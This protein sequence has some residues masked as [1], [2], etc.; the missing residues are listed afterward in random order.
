M[1][2]VGVWRDHPKEHKVKADADKEKG[3]R[4]LDFRQ[5]FRPSVSKTMGWEQLP[6][7]NTPSGEGLRGEKGLIGGK[8]LRVNSILFNRFAWCPPKCKNA[9]CYRD[10]EVPFPWGSSS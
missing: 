7:L 10:T 6:D 9:K 3:E 8:L 1:T 5:G 4:W 2:F